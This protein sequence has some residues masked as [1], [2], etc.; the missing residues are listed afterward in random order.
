QPLDPIIA[1]ISPASTLSD[2]RSSARM[3]VPSG[4]RKVLLTSRMST[5]E[6]L[7]PIRELEPTVLVSPPLAIANSAFSFQLLSEHQ[8]MDSSLAANVYSCSSGICV[9]DSARPCLR[10]CY[11]LDSFLI[12][13]S[14]AEMNCFSLTAAHG[15][16]CEH[17]FLNLWD[18]RL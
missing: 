12:L 17:S 14:T 18:T 16:C 5:E 4:V 1:T 7:S 15:I 3:V 9:I 2:M 13:F 8:A 6:A 10:R 11:G